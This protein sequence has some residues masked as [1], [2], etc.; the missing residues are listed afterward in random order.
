[1]GIMG[2]VVAPELAFSQTNL[3]WNRSVRDLAQ[4]EIGL[5]RLGKNKPPDFQGYPPFHLDN[6]FNLGRKH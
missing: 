5:E 3:Q 1:M 6:P 4:P 2:V